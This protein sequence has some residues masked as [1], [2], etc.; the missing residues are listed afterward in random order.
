MQNNVTVNENGGSFKLNFAGGY[1]EG[2]KK[3]FLS[4]DDSFM[5]NSFRAHAD[6]SNINHTLYLNEG[7][8]EIDVGKGK[9]KYVLQNVRG[10]K[11]ILDKEQRKLTELETYLDFKDHSEWK[12]R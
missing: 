1:L 11:K 8:V 2:R 4:K 5:I 7:G 10:T 3:L 9:I 6:T 12:E